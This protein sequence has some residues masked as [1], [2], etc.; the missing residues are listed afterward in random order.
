MSTIDDLAKVERDI[1]FLISC[2][3]NVLDELDEHDLAAGL[4]WQQN[5]PGAPIAAPPE[6]IAQAYAIAFHLLNIAEENAAIQT[7]RM[8]ETARGLTY[9]PGLWGRSLQQLADELTPEQIAE[10]L[11]G[12]HV[13]PVLTAHPTEA[14]HAT[15][16]EHHRELYLL[17]VRR[18]NPILT[19]QEQQA[20]RD[21]IVA[22]LERLWRTGEIFLSRPD[23][24]S[25]VRNVIH[26]LRNVFPDVLPVLDLRLRQA[27]RDAGFAPRLLEDTGTLPRLT[28]GVW[29]GGD[30]DG[31]PFV[32]A[33]V[34]RQ[35]LHDLHRN[36]L[37]LLRR[38]L[39][40]LAVRLSLSD[41]LQT[42]S[43]DLLRWIDETARAL[44]PRGRQA[45]E[46]NPNEPW[47]QFLNL[48]VA[49]LPLDETPGDGA[50]LHD[51]EGA[52]H[53][54]DELA[55]DLQ[56]L[57]AD[58]RAAG[59]A[60][61]ATADV[62]P[63]QR[64]VQI[65]G[66]HLAALDVRQNSRFHDLAVA[67]LLAAAGLDGA[68]FPDWDEPRRLEFLNREL[69]SPRPF[70]HP[71]SPLG[72]EAS[73]VVS[74]YRVLAE[75]LATYGP[76]GLGALIVSMT[77]SL[78]DLLVVYLLAREAGLAALTPE[79]LVCRLPV[80][81]LF[82][83]IQD[84]ERSPAILAAFLDHPITRR[85]GGVQQV[86]IGYSDSNKDGGILASQWSL[87]R[88][89]VALTEVG[90]SRGV[91]VRFFHGRGGTISRGAGPTHRFLAALP[92]GSLGGDLRVT[93]QGEAIA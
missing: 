22:M 76:D 28:F 46:R 65:F 16:L 42:P 88:A 87:Y 81:P 39:T 26:Y 79:G 40:S 2:F 52:Y 21:E 69:E 57:A 14:K 12:I 24:A 49:R 45:V 71:S 8:G 72:P 51:W 53:R 17:L 11:A 60:R 29:V 80:V 43:A 70:A 30:R 19:P 56:A 13:E 23:V 18:E 48:V 50:G 25:E 91:R 5:A 36:A 84:L 63:V 34:T 67:E 54:A 4:P 77:R 93:E 62:E 7:R 32:T 66:F 90:H 38:Q 59:A 68:D 74:C 27:W 83:T 55:G 78:S 6:R 58:F 61:I 35:T 89:Q 64:T 86:M 41:Q 9:E 73:A 92:P 1:H 47:R 33:E 3:H 20:I 31:H 10:A 44:G 82:E 15:V 85:A 75:Y 37:L